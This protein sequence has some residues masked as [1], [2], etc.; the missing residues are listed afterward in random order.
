MGRSEKIKVEKHISK[1]ELIKKIRQLEI[2]KRILKRLYF[3]KL[4]YDDVPV[5]KACK[6]VGVSKTVAYEWQER[7]NNEGYRGII[8]KFAGG[9]PSKLT[10]EQQNEIKQILNMNE[11]ISI[12]ELRDLIYKKYN[13][14]Y[15]LKQ[16]RENLKK[17]TDR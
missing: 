17:W 11:D 2:Q 5:E 6:Q 13:I 12:K 3:I 1:S 15:S 7:W 8:P 14:K 9:R 4:R 10:K 16:V